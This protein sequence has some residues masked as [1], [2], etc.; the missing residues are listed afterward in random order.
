MLKFQF[1]YDARCDW[2]YIALYLLKNNGFTNSYFDVL[3]FSVLNVESEWKKKLCT[4]SNFR[5]SALGEQF[6]VDTNGQ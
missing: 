2:R 5:S 1:A 6:T 3:F 4:D